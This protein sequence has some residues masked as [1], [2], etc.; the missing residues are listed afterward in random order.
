MLV[1]Q[2]GSL[3]LLQQRLLDVG[4]CALPLVA[5]AARH[6]PDWLQPGWMPQALLACP[7]AWQCPA[8]L[9]LHRQE[10]QA[11][12]IGWLV[13]PHLMCQQPLR[14]PQTLVPPA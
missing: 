6:P 14:L 4:Q 13:A 10:P 8:W 1:L 5:M 9:R 11:Q 3:Q 12:G 2:T 7:R